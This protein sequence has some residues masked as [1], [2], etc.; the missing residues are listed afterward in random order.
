MRVAVLNDVHGNL[1]ALQ[2]ALGDVGRASADRIV[3][4]GDVLWGPYQSECLALLREGGAEFLAGNTEREVL[5]GEG[6]QNAWCLG[7]LSEQERAF[8]SAWPSSLELAIDGLGLVFF[9]H[10]TPR[11][12]TEIITELT[13]SPALETAIESAAAE[14]VVVGH[15]HQQFDL[16]LGRKRLVNA[17][18]VGLP[19]EG[20]PGA[21]WALLGPGVELRRTDYDIERAAVYLRSSGMPGIEDLLGD[22]LLA[23]ADRDV[24]SAWFEGRRPAGR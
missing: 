5:Q 17:G 15:T 6:E 12:D 3:C 20:R 19:Y 9:C 11:S 2:A 13:P 22:S 16:A 21:F 24:V 1:P 4:G 18:S 23:P 7:R 8:I 14:V 10:A